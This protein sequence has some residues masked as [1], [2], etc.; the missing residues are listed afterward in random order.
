MLSLTICLFHLIMYYPKHSNMKQIVISFFLIIVQLTG[1]SQIDGLYRTQQT[2]DSSGYY[3]LYVVLKEGRYAITLINNNSSSGIFDDCDISVGRYTVNH[4]RVTLC[5][6]ILGI[7]MVLKQ[8][9]NGDLK[10][11]NGFS[12]LRSIVFKK[13]KSC[14][15]DSIEDYREINKKQLEIDTAEYQRQNI[16]TEIALG[17]Y[18]CGAAFYCSLFILPNQQYKYYCRGFMVSKGKW[19]RKG[20]L[21][22][23]IDHGG[24]KQLYALKEPIGINGMYLPGAST[25]CIMVLAE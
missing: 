23:L 5:D 19:K 14:L 6:D 15:N 20:N 24:T 9:K 1:Y 21:I 2:N 10:I 11:I 12:P 25:D 17:S 22:V 8:K 7:E 18:E 3:S 13:E 4:R 16:N